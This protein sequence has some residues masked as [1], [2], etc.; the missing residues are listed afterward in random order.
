MPSYAI[1]RI[2]RNPKQI[3]LHRSVGRKDLY[4]GRKALLN[5]LFLAEDALQHLIEVS[6]GHACWWPAF[7]RGLPGKPLEQFIHRSRHTKLAP[8]Q[9]DLS[10]EVVTFN[11]ARPT[12]QALP[13][14]AAGT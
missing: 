8:E 2:S 9:H 14:G 6:H 7:N 3:A 12:R 1:V 13:R 4:E 5:S 11:A 10:I